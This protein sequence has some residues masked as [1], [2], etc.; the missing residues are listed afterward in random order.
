MDVTGQ[1]KEG[2]GLRFA[3]QSNGPLAQVLE[4]AISLVDQPVFANVWHFGFALCHF[5]WTF[6]RP[7]QEVPRLVTYLSI[8]KA[9]LLIDEWSI[10]V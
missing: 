10:W 8:R 3:V 4:P 2:P 7:W 1:Q 9:S 5:A 6:Y